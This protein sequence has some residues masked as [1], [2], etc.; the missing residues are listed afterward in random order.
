M[1]VVS[2]LPMRL[3][4]SLPLQAS[5]SIGFFPQRPLLALQKVYPWNEGYS[6][7]CMECYEMFTTGGESYDGT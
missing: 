5:G 3:L 4:I 1:L 6:Q 7:Q 2:V